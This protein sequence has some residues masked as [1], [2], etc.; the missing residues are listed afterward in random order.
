MKFTSARAARGGTLEPDLTPMIDAVFNLLIFF[1]LTLVV[2]TESNIDVPAS[3]NFEKPKPGA[4]LML[5][6]DRPT[7]KADGL[8]E[9]PGA[10]R[11]DGDPVTIDQL[12]AKIQEYR[13]RKM[14]TERIVIK[15]DRFTFYKSVKMVM[16]SARDAGITKFLVATQEPS[17]TH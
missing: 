15:A 1:L 4:E 8:L 16:N 17:R 9:K 10:I 11:L 14:N 2:K 6:I 7:F 12:V 13:V 5:E 3:E